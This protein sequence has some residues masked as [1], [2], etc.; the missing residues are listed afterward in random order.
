M[1]EKDTNFILIKEKLLEA[2]EIT[3]IT[4]IKDKICHLIQDIEDYE[5]K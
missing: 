5:K 3:D 4:F 1:G 2:I